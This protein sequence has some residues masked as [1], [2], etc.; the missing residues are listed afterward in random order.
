MLNVTFRRI[1]AAA[2]AEV[3]ATLVS[4]GDRSDE[5][6]EALRQETSSEEACFLIP[7]SDEYVL[8]FA[9]WLA[10]PKRAADAFAAS[11]LPI[12]LEL[13]ELISKSSPG[14]GAA[15]PLYRVAVDSGA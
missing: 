1:H 14:R 13:K 3:R 5:L 15:E 2:A 7:P 10:D 12:D 6:V 11:R 8:I 9:S 4:M